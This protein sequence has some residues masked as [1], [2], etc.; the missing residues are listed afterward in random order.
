MENYQLVVFILFMCFLIFKSN[1]EFK[2]A[3]GH[4]CSDA[5]FARISAAVL[6]CVALFGIALI[7]I[8]TNLAGFENTLK[9]GIFSSI[10]AVLIAIYSV[11]EIELCKSDKNIKNIEYPIFSALFY[12]VMTAELILVFI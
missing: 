12:L 11:K 9:L 8:S 6:A 4:Y 2:S 5:K 1:L 3:V 10:L 7:E